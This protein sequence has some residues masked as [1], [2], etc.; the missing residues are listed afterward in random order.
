ML[1]I[2]SLLLAT[3]ISGLCLSFTVISFWRVNRGSGF[4]VTWAAAIVVLVGHVAAF[5]LYDQTLSPIFGTVACALLPLGAI[6]LYAAN[7]QYAHSTSPIPIILSIAIPYLVL[8]PPVFAL[9]YDGLALVAQNGLT[10]AM[11]YLCAWTCFSARRG[12]LFSLSSLSALYLLLGVSFSL[13]GL[14]LL[15]Q[16]QWSIGYPPTNWA[17]DIN[18]VMSVLGMT[19]VGALTLLLDQS[20]IADSFQRA[21]MI[22]PMTGLLNRRALQAAH[23][24]PFG[25]RKAVV[26]FDLDHFKQVN[27]RHGHAVGDEVLKG[28]ARAF[29]DNA[30]NVDHVI[31]LGGEEFAMVMDGVSPEQA[32]KIAERVLSAFAAIVFP[33]AEVES[34]CCT[35]SAGIAF[36]D[37]NMPSLEDV[38]ARADRALY[39]AKRLGRNRIEVGEWRLAG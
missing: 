22:D 12:A 29:Q 4:M 14:V 6:G 33:G 23:A 8:V 16:G 10:A 31:R 36:G 18:V 11:F 27:D 38:M 25:P 7:R 39:T 19:G 35:V 20:R 5:W 34:F 26:L 30:R 15:A 2:N 24:G 32:R 28:F 37:D 3:A 1:D 9:G 13:C 17:E 21:A